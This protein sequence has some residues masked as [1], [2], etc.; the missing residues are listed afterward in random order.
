MAAIGSVDADAMPD[1]LKGKS[2]E[3]QAR[4]IA[5]NQKKR[6]AIQ[7]QIASVSKQREAHL[8][9][10]ALKAGTTADGFDEEVKATRGRDVIGFTRIFVLFCALVLLPALMLSGF[11]VIAI[12]NERQAEK[13]RRADQGLEALKDAQRAFAAILEATDRE[14]RATLDRTDTAVALDALAGPAAAGASRFFALGPWVLFAPDRTLLD[15]RPPLSDDADVLLHLAKL[16]QRAEVG[17]P[18]HA[19]IAMGSLSAVV[20]LQRGADGRVLV[21]VLDDAKLDA[22]LRAR[23]AGPLRTGVRVVGGDDEPVMNA[24]ERLVQIVRT[25]DEPTA[26]P[27]E[28]PEEIATKTL[29]PPF[30]RFTLVISTTAPSTHATLIA[31]VV[32]LVVFL[33]TLI[34]GVVITARLIWQETRLSRLKTDFVSHMSHELRTPLTSIRMFIETLKMGRASPEEAAECLHL[35]AKETERLSEMI[36]RVLGYARLRAGRRLFS[37]VAVPVAAAVEEALDAFRAHTLAD[38][39]LALITDV[40]AHLPPMHVDREAFVEALLNLVSNAYKYTG[41][42]KEITVFA[43]AGKRGRIVVGVKDNGPGLPKQEHKRV[44]DRFYRAGG[45]L[46]STKAGSGL[47]LAI[48]RAIVEGNGGKI[49]IESEPGKGATFTMDLSQVRDTARPA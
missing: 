22:A 44:F 48:T 1:E 27:L 25:R 41:P 47:G 16:S 5:T 18:A 13:Q 8:K 21:F 43:H 46:S 31:Y 39:D 34:T 33:A 20:S 15:G 40:E 4:V 26:S 28:A 29:A 45:L 14:G 23:V 30:D 6:A 19:A 32:L 7:Q 17:R 3:E 9:D 11:G 38:E 10:A 2:K 42:H 24:V 35:L 12:M 37:P 36:E 49:A